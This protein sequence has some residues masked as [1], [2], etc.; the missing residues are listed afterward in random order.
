MEQEPEQTVLKAAIAAVHRTTGIKLKA[1]HQVKHENKVADA[2]ITIEGHKKVH[3]T[4]EVKKWAQQ[5]NFGAMVNQIQQL[6][7][8][9]MLVADYIDPKMADRLR[10]LDIP[11]IDTFGN[12]YINDKPIYIFVKT[13][14]SQGQ[15][16]A[17]RERNLKGMLKTVTQGR[18]F[19]LT[20][21]KVV[22][23][24]MKNEKLLNA[25]Y[26]EIAEK[27]D[28]ALGTV[29][30]V[31]NDLKQGRYLIEIPPK[32]RRLKNK[33][34][35]FDKWVDAYLT[36]LRPKLFVGTYRAENEY[37][38]QELDNLKTEY[39][40][41]WGG[42]VAAAK[43]TGYL[44]PEKAIVYLPKVG[45]EDLFQKQRFRKDT[46]GNIQVFRAF[47]E[48]DPKDKNDILDTVD[49][50]IVYADLLET[51]DVRNQEAAKILYQNELTEFIR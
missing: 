33:K 10:E 49:P 12:V 50:I 40:A 8:K 2:E 35:L 25:P 51:G 22:Y 7:G 21:L 45:G 37:W 44:K 38:W 11:Y 46:N 16:E 39:D 4:A 18:A 1:R 24:F 9:G 34:E 41:Q 20:G 43:L 15:A 36:K 26:R 29:G 32:K 30:W 14:K 27:T 47:W 5:A 6:P 42:E 48:R 23:A 28:V 19:N 31:I 13:T 3:Y 17:N